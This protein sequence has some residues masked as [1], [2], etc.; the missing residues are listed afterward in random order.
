MAAGNQ[1]ANRKAAKKLADDSLG[2][3]TSWRTRS[4][5]ARA[6]RFVETF[7]VPSKGYGAG[8]ALKLAPYQRDWLEE[9]LADG[10]SSAAMS[11]GRGNGKSTFMAALGLWATF[12]ADETGAPQ[13]PVVAT[14]VNQA[15]RAT[16]GV[17]LAMLRKH[18]D[19]A[20]RSHVYSAIGNQ[21]IIVPSVE[22]EMFPISNDVDGLQGLDPSLA[23]IDE[24][25]FMPIESWDALQLASGKRSR[26]LVAAVGTPGYDRSSALWH[27][28]NAVIEGQV[29]HGFSWTEYAADEGCDIRDEAQWAKAN[30]ALAAGYMNPAALRT[31]VEMTLEGPFRIFRLGQWVDGVESWLGENSRAMWNALAQPYEF[32]TTAPTFLGVDVGLKRDS[33]AVVS[34][35]SR[36]DGRQHAKAQIWTPT[37]DRKLDVSDIVAHVRGECTR[38][39][40]A[41]VFYDPRLFELA[42]A[43]LLDE[44]FPMVE[45]PQSLE[46]MTPAVGGA[47]DAIKRGDLTHDGDALFDA[48]ILAAAARLNE[49]GF[50]V[51][52]SKSRDPIDACV[53]LVLA[54][55]ASNS[56]KPEPAKRPVFSA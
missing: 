16:Y 43:Q 42:G 35:Q 19:L 40:V 44:G 47:F 29:P 13:V 2:P 39:N 4:R 23:I 31:A 17:A 51:S 37:T 25:G 6:I 33:S 27:L 9:V 1:T 14:T 45:F 18:P 49:R 12:D 24:V 56:P 8:K 10:V 55:A 3:W 53:A 46:R 32:T 30:P 41:A 54:L 48:H 52:K 7:C 38:L 15:I 20:D 50:T 28:R 5:A 36:P 11:L 22:G 21:R 34:I 26:S